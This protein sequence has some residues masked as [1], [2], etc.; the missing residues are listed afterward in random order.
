MPQFA[1]SRHLVHKADCDVYNVDLS[2]RAKYIKQM[3]KRDNI[4]KTR[5]EN[6]VLH[7]T[8]PIL[9]RLSKKWAKTG[10]QSNRVCL[11]VCNAFKAGYNNVE[12]A[13]EIW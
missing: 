8:M 2:R 12:I 9:T 3:L 5:S 7:T 10:Q 11:L 1:I 13:L 6:I 4:Y